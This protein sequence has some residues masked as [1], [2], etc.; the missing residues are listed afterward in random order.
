MANMWANIK[1]LI[2]CSSKI[3][4]KGKCI[5]D[6]VIYGEEKRTKTMAKHLENESVLL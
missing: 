2:F 6:V 5:V 4:D 1:Y 3:N